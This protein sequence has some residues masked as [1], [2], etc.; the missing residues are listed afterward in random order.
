VRSGSESITQEF[1]AVGAT[2]KLA[3]DIHDPIEIQV[4]RTK[5]RRPTARNAT[6]PAACRPGSFRGSRCPIQ[7]LL[8]LSDEVACAADSRALCTLA[9]VALTA[10]AITR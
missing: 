1:G 5:Q 8:S 7:D 3:V 4:A 2:I 6:R 10:S 9:F